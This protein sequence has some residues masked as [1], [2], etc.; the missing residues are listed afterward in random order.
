MAI[1]GSISIFHGIGRRL[2][3][4]FSLFFLIPLLTVSYTGYQQSKEAIRRQVSDHFQSLLDLQ[5]EALR[6]YF[7]Q[8]ELQLSST[9]AQNEFLLISTVVVQSTTFAKADVEAGR[10]RLE[11]FTADKARELG[12]RGLR[13]LGR[14]GRVLPLRSGGRPVPTVRPRPPSPPTAGGDRY[15]R[16]ST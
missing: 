4:W 12:A 15:R 11:R 5:Q 1:P 16:G 6:N 9:V 3:L 14:N 10:R 7:Q 2:L 13:I 8:K